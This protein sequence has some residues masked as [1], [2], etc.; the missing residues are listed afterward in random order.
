MHCLASGPQ[1]QV[2]SRILVIAATVFFRDDPSSS[3][4]NIPAGL[5]DAHDLIKEH[6]GKGTVVEYSRKAESDLG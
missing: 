2:L 6:I 4:K 1:L 3:S 5:F